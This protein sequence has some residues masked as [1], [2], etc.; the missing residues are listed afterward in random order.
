MPD[1]PSRT[2]YKAK[3]RRESRAEA[4]DIGPV[5][6]VQRPDLKESGR[7]DLL[8]FLRSYL[9]NRFP[10]PFSE[11][12]LALIASIQGIILHGGLRALAM[13]RG[14]GKTTI[15]EGAAL[16]A[17]LYGHRRF[18]MIV[19]ATSRAARLLMNSI[20][21][22]LAFN[23]EL[24]ADF[25]EAV[26]AIR[27]LGGVARRAEAQT[28][29]GMPTHL[30]WTRDEVR[31]PATASG[32]GSVISIAGITGAIRGAK[33]T[34][35]DGA[36]VR[37]DL[38]LVDDF[39]TR[40]SA[41]SPNQTANRL[42]I[43]ASDVLGLAGPGQR[44]ACLCACTVIQRGD[45]A[46][47]LLDR[48]AHPEWQGSTAQLMRSMPAKS[49]IALWDQY[50]EIYREDLAREDLPQESKLDRATRF[51]R[52]HRTKLD[53]GAVASWEARKSEGEESAIQ[54]AMNLLLTRGEDAFWAE[55]QNAPRDLASSQT[56]QLEAA[57]L[58][59]RINR[60][61]PGIVPRGAVELTAAIDV[62]EGCLWWG[63]LATGEAFRGDLVAY[64]AWPDPG[65]RL[66]TKIEMRG[67]LARAYPAE[68]MEGTW[69]LAFT[70]LASH[71]LDR[72]WIDEDGIVRRVSLMLIDAGYGH[73][74][75]TVFEWA[76]RSPWKDRIYP[77]RGKGI[78][79]K[80]SPMADW[81]KIPG[82]KLGPNWRITLNKAR[83]SREVVMGVNYWKSFVAARLAA[84]AGGLGSLSFNGDR[85][86]DHELLAGHLTAEKRDTVSTN[87]RTIDEWRPKPGQDN[88]LLDVVVACHVAASIR[89]ISFDTGSRVQADSPRVSLAERQR[90]ARAKRGQ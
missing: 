76:K 41:K 32:G 54:H 50:A 59:T 52:Q 82:D 1:T 69:H 56:P 14:S 34:L 39:Q 55:F 33:A 16:W 45:G 75:D 35:A 77:S 85:P 31:L 57:A 78:G 17:L 88:D 63:V 65:R 73:S 84:P 6:P 51:Y 37:P 70:A 9:S 25:P 87:D 20:R 58:A 22:E 44:V 40:D 19:A 80:S 11:D 29:E 79:A 30:V 68:T 27:A 64:G 38:C 62:G 36:Q 15:V 12:H 7:L 72:D 8:V 66:F 47:Q 43:L 21:D 42:Q 23:D 61:R 13:P 10:L 3:H 49:A 28:S 60:V 83:K 5:P 26:A 86:A 48:K 18:L 81:K 4:R 46:A 90:L 71:I 74:T 2:A 89:G 67:A 53:A 24:A